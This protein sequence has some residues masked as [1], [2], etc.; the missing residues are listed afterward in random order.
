MRRAKAG[1]DETLCNARI[2]EGEIYGVPVPGGSPNRGP[3]RVIRDALAKLR[4]R[5]TSAGDGDGAQAATSHSPESKAPP[6]G[7]EGPGIQ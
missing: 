1:G 5:R 6:S 7:T 3:F 4:R 2:I